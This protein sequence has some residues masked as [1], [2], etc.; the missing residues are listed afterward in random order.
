MTPK[1]PLWKCKNCV[2]FN[3]RCPL[4]DLDPCSYVPKSEMSPFYVLLLIVITLL[5]IVAFMNL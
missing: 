1:V 4:E 5:L 2:R 3:G